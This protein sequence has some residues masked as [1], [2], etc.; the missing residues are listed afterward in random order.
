M[1]VGEHISDFS[2]PCKLRCGTSV[3]CIAFE[4]PFIYV[5]KI[6]SLKL[7]LEASYLFPWLVFYTNVDEI[8]IALHAKV[9]CKSQHRFK[10][11][12]WF[13]YY[14]SFIVNIPSSF[15]IKFLVG[16]SN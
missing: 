4:L 7:P 1:F 6:L 13:S 2:L 8:S 16:N 15:I 9:F 5:S 14:V 3:V 11:P 12:H 10:Q